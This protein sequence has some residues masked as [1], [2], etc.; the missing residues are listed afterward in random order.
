M[1][2]LLLFYGLSLAILMEVVIKD[3]SVSL[4]ALL[5]DTIKSGCDW[6]AHIEKDG[7]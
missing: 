1:I 6:D 5:C 7:K 2:Y 3:V 4:Y